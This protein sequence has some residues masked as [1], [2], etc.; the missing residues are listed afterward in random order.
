MPVSMA[1]FFADLMSR[2]RNNSFG[3]G[4]VQHVAPQSLDSGGFQL[5]LVAHLVVVLLMVLCPK[6]FAMMLPG[7]PGCAGAGGGKG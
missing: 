1:C 7:W 4:F 2:L 3:N 6:E 5:A